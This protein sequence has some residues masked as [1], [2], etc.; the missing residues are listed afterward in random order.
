MGD[1]TR[2]KWQSS[3]QLK[4]CCVCGVSIAPGNRLCAVCRPA[5]PRSQVSESDHGPLFPSYVLPTILSV[6]FLGPISCFYLLVA[7]F[8]VEDKGDGKP[9]LPL[10][11]S[12]GVFVSMVL[13]IWTAFRLHKRA[14]LREEVISE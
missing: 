11:I 2:D 4:K 13:I 3:T 7:L 1:S 6:L 10:L 8:I 9:M 14:K 12:A 5:I